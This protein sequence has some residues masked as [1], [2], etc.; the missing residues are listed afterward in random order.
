MDEAYFKP[1]IEEDPKYAKAYSGLSDTY[2]LLGDW[3]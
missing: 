1:A 3:Q 2:A